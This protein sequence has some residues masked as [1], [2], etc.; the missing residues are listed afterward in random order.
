MPIE[1]DA[2]ETHISVREA[3]GAWVKAILQ[4]PFLSNYYQGADYHYLLDRISRSIPRP[5]IKVARMSTPGYIYRFAWQAAACGVPVSAVA[6]FR[7]SGNEIFISLF[8]YCSIF[9]QNN[10]G[11]HEV[12]NNMSQFEDTPQAPGAM[13][14]EDTSSRQTPELDGKHPLENHDGD[15]NG[16]ENKRIK[17]EEHTESK[18]GPTKA[19]PMSVA[20][21]ENGGMVVVPPAQPQLFYVPL[22]TGL[23]YDVRMRYHAKIFTSYFEYIDPHPEDPRRIY[24]IYKKLAETGL[25][26]DTSL[27]GSDHLGP[28]MTKI[29]V[30][31]ATAEEIL[32]VHSKEHLLYIQSTEKMSRDQLL[33]ETEK[34]DSIYVNN[35]S[36]LSAKLSC[37]GAIEACKAVVEGTVKNS[38]AIVRPP[39]HHAEPDTPGGFC[40]FSNVAVA[41]KNILKNYPESVR[42]IVIIDW[43][44]HHGN[45]TQ[46]AFYNDPRVLYISLHRYENGRFYPGTKYGHYS[47][48]G[49][50]PGE[51]YSVNIPW[52][53]PGKGDGDY[54]YAFN[55]IILPVINEFNPDL[56]IVSSGFDAA[57]GDIIGGC[58]VTPVGYG[59]MTHLLK[60]IARGNLA[61]ILEGGYNLDSIT[62]GALAVT[63]VLLGEPPENTISALPLS[64]T[65][66]TVDEVM[67]ALAQYWK[68]MRI[69]M[70]KQSFEDVFDL[71]TNTNAY[72]LTNIAD[73][74]R[75]HQA[76]ELFEKYNFVN[77][78]IVTAATADTKSSYFTDMPSRK[79]D[80]ILASPDIYKAETLVV[81]IHDP[82]EIWANIE[83]NSGT[84]DGGS[85]VVLEHPMV[86][87]MEK[88]KSELAESS[89]PSN[90]KLGFMDIEI[91]SLALPSKPIGSLANPSV[92]TYSPTIF[93]QELLLYV[94]DNYITYFSNI[95]KIVFV[96][97]GD[98]Y[99]AIVHLYS[100]RP[101]QEI[102]EVV[103][104]TIAFAA[105]SPLKPLVSV[106]D[107]SM[108]DWYYQN[109]VVF[110]SHLN[111]CWTSTGSGRAADSADENKRPRR[112][113]GRVLKSG[114][115]NLWD[116][117][118]DKFNEGID[119]VLDSI[120]DLSG[121][122]ESS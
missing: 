26:H 102:K 121:T 20:L 45:G 72:K 52:N 99:Q 18:N 87:I 59:Y 73:T 115:D 86:Q 57:D 25:I 88:V 104:G 2:C 77:L 110:T 74:I 51:G 41:A 16:A 120:E 83:P 35:D 69:G 12:V 34:G 50:G 3:A 14:L 61:V 63:K 108:V 40:L 113:F 117:I 46:K 122:E 98:A 106:M 101:P 43:D 76:N 17:L 7:L 58:H 8:L 55:K 95:K 103:K 42:R 116:V 9:S 38:M 44:I 118:S 107:E 91:P 93:S 100:K 56:L 71:S 24:R 96:G 82:H 31:E 10:R 15:T 28:Y 78:P 32:E 111:S 22:K 114:S 79:D 19:E 30:R 48:V 64:D 90:E 49:E 112:K 33:E 67:K 60:G 70:P 62:N 81:T 92:S 21:K 54:V 75:S 53:C 36:Y 85:S 6:S 94:W 97:F 80:L 89:E 65:I 105:K 1:K 37:G 47:N 4:K 11:A 109:S 13:K 119:F 84:I 68:C 66:E 29:P 39:G 27:S 23:V 5:C